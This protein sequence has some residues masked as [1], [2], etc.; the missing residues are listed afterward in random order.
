MKTIRS[1]ALLATFVACCATAPAGA[2]PQRPATPFL[3]AV[4]D[5]VSPAFPVTRA[6]VEASCRLGGSPRAQKRCARTN[7]AAR[8][9]GKPLWAAASQDLRER[10]HVDSDKRSAAA[11]I[12]SCLRDRRE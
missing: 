5:I 9:S 1:L 7:E 2:A 10:C 6:Q 8:Q 11:M 3:R 12:T 4:A